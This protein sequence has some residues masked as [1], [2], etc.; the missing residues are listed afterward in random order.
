[1]TEESK[2]VVPE[3]PD[4]ERKRKQRERKQA[5][6]TRQRKEREEAAADE[7][8]A[9]ASSESGCIK[10]IKKIWREN[11]QTRSETERERVNNLVQDWNYIFGLLFLG[12]RLRT[13]SR[14]PWKEEFPAYGS[15]D[16]KGYYPPFCPEQDF[17]EVEEYAR[18]HLATEQTESH[19]TFLR[20]ITKDRKIADEAYYFRTFGAGIDGIDGGMYHSYLNHFGEWYRQNRNTLVL[21]TDT[22]YG[23]EF[24]KTWEEI[25]A[26]MLQNPRVA[27]NVGMMKER[28]ESTPPA[29]AVP[30]R[31]LTQHE[32]VQRTVDQLRSIPDREI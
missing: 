1:M 20:D 7:A 31:L 28:R 14:Q 16:D 25:D 4:E 3:T 9:E 26:L 12:Y 11:F 10:T 27:H 18:E 32:E 29:S 30:A 21:A 8:L 24:A 23:P 13:V 22:E 17:A 5:Q 19:R 15:V 6:R 2:Q